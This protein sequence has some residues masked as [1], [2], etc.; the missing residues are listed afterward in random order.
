MSEVE[1]RLRGLQKKAIE[2]ANNAPL[3]EEPIEI[4]KDID[5][6]R[7]RE[8]AAEIVVP[9]GTLSDEDKIKWE[10]DKASPEVAVSLPIL[11]DP[12]EI[13]VLS[14]TTIPFVPSKVSSGE[15]IPSSTQKF[16]ILVETLQP[17]Q[18]GK[19]YTLVL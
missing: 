4:P 1:N 15:D 3:R 2:K 5:E 11:E 6:D 7:L 12:A 16:Q 13:L 14:V 10:K 19:K 8:V 9:Q 17:L 18:L